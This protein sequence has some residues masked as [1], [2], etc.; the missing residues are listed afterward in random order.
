MWGKDFI[1]N[2]L[3]GTVKRKMPNHKFQ[4]SDEKEEPA[5]TSGLR[6]LKEA[7]GNPFA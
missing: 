1:I 6:N 5:K 7:E 3:Q 2:Q 4:T